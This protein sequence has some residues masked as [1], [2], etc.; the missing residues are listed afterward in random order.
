MEIAIDDVF[1]GRGNLPDVRTISAPLRPG[2]LKVFLL[3]QALYDLLRDKDPLS[4]QRCLN[5][6]VTVRAMITLEDVG[7]C[8]TDFRILVATPQARPVVEVGT[9]RE[10]QA[11]QKLR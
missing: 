7:D 1:R 9:P 2:R 10:I 4:I 11:I 5:P 6:T 3:H 8:A